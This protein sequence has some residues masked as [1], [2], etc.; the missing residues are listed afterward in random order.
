[1]RSSRTRPVRSLV[2]SGLRSEAWTEGIA[3]AWAHETGD[4]L[5]N[6]VFILLFPWPRSYPSLVVCWAHLL[7]CASSPPSP[8]R[9]AP[10]QR[11]QGSPVAIH[12][13]QG[14]GRS[15]RVCR[16]IAS[17]SRRR[18]GV[19]SGLHAWD[20]GCNPQ[21]GDPG[22]VGICGRPSCAARVICAKHA[23][24]ARSWRNT[25]VAVFP[26]SLL[27]EARPGARK[28]QRKGTKRQISSYQQQ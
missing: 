21:Q 15:S 14:T 3:A 13:R 4:L 11:R 25:A 1:M 24:R 12:G 7:S 9:V 19:R 8:L 6:W 2:R 22:V 20:S 18:R 10:L 23:C 17:K 28:Q 5:D 16:Q 27:D 26:T